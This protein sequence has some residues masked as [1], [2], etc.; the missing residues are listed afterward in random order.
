[1]E[2]EN[3]KV[4]VKPQVVSTEETPPQA[5]KVS[6]DSL[7]TPLAENMPVPTGPLPEPP[8]DDFPPDPNLQENAP[9]TDTVKDRV[10][11]VF[12]PSIYKRDEK[13]APRLD[14]SGCF[15]PVNK[16]RKPGSK[17]DKEKPVTLAESQNV[18]GIPDEYD[19]AAAMYFDMTTGAL[20]GFISD[21][22]N[23]DNDAERAGMLKVV[24]AYLRAKGSIDVTPGQA[25]CFASIG[26]IGK[27][28][29]KPKT[30]ERL[31]LWWLKA[32]EFFGKK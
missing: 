16:G 23:P 11:N 10:G 1:M 21:E 26:Y 17:N 15:I 18:S 9:K 31:V 13:G 7:V 29:N 30:K 27:R 19:H 12:D 32:K 20:A 5:E 8:P 25:L 22:W 4:E 24:A 14:K 6:A 3:E 2:K 28:V